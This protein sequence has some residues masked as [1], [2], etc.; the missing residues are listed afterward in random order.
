MSSRAAAAARKRKTWPLYLLVAVTAAPALAAWVVYSVPG[1]LPEA[2]GN[3]GALVQPALAMPE[4]ID[5]RVFSGQWSMV[6]WAG[7]SCGDACRARVHDMRQVRLALAEHRDRTG[8]F[9]LAADGAKG[10][11]EAVASWPGAQ[12]LEPG[13][14]ALA[15]LV[16]KM[17]SAGAAPE[18][19]SVYLVDPMGDLMMAYG[20]Q[21]PA[22][23][24]LADLEKLFQASKN[25]IDGVKDGNE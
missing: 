18:G 22:E 5:A 12:V 10:V 9:V 20:P 2:R 4:S 13:D 24:I 23:D 8:R 21:Q 6:A 16:A 14:A 19:G 15:E 11:A 17:K 3:R 1:L 7:G 25:W